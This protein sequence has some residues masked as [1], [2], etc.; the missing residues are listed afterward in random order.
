MTEEQTML[1]DTADRY[2]RENTDF[3]QRRDQI[4][5]AIYNQP[6]KWQAFAEM[7]WLAMP[8]PE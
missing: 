7:G 4:A 5:E 2:L 3:N 8:F 6:Q 1:W